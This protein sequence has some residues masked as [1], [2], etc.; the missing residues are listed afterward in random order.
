[1]KN[2]TIIIAATVVIVLVA[3]G[4][5]AALNLSS[6]PTAADNKTQ[7]TASGSKLTIIN[8]NQDVWAHWKLEIRNVPE[9]NGTQQTYYVDAYIKPGENV[10]FDLSTIAGN[11]DKPLAQDTNITVLGWGGLHNATAGGEGKFNSTLFGWTTDEV[12]PTPAAT[13]KNATNPLEVDPVQAIGALPANITEN[14]ITI[15]TSNPGTDTDDELFIQI[16]IIIGPDG[17][18]YFELRGTPVLCEV[19]AQG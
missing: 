19:I 13:Y 12:L 9:A 5:F 7:V 4:V 11:G 18:P 3:A 15:G 14:T 17:I 2:S 16:N 1:M 8:N 6:S 10:T